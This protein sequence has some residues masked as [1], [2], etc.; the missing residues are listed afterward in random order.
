[1]LEHMLQVVLQASAFND[2]S[3]A[4]FLISLSFQRQHHASYSVQVNWAVV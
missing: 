4:C 1:M 3:I 2:T